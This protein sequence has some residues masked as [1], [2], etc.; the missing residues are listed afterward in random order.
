MVEAFERLKEHR[1][2]IAGV[3]PLEV[4]LREYIAA[5][6]VKNVELVGFKTGAEKWNFVAVVARL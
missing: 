3:G 4:H 5:N 6:H 2:K 1:L